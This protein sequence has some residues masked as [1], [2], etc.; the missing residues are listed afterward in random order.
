[1]TSSQDHHILLILSWYPIQED[2]LEGIFF[3]EQALILK[4][5]GMRIG[6]IYPEI[7]PLKEISYHLLKSNYFQYTF[8]QEA[9]MPTHRLHGWNLF[10]GF[11]KG[12]MK[13]WTSCARALFKRYVQK[14]GMPSIIHAQ[15]VI[16]A[17]VAAAEI[18]HMTGIPYLIQEHRDLFLQPALFK[19]ILSPHW[20]KNLMKK[21]LGKASAIVSVSNMLKKEMEKYLYPSLKAVEVVP[22]FIDIEGFGIPQRPSSDKPFV[23][24]TLAV[25]VAKKNINLLLRAFKHVQSQEPASQLL[26]GGDGVERANLERL[27][28]Q[29]DLNSHVQFLGRVS[30]DQLEKVFA[31]AHAFVLPS[32]YESFGVVFIE[33]LAMGL[34]VIGTVCGGPEDIITPEV[35][36]LLPKI[37]EASLVQAMLD[38]KA[39]YSRYDPLTLKDYAQKKFGGKALTK[40]WIDLYNTIGASSGDEKS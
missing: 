39:C 19:N 5:A 11:L 26:I 23:F 16:W 31:R 3:F 8:A 27:C 38:L 25:L 10:P 21:S 18:S 9:G 33:A 37:D 15:S 6:I 7:R 29:L 13:L 20:S 34:P 14:E 36:I 30:R 22:N 17:G 4:K 1:M 40:K 12:T 28:Q 2:S 24:L 32:Q 35:G